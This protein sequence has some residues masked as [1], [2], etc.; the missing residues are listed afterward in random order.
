MHEMRV[1]EAVI[2]LVTICGISLVSHAAMALQKRH[3]VADSCLLHRWTIL[4][5]QVRR[6]IGVL[7]QGQRRY[8]HRHAQP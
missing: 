7:L 4:L 2:V 6:W 5:V 8:V 1:Q 3:G